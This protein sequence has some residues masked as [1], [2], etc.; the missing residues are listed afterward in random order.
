LENPPTSKLSAPVTVVVAMDDPATAGSVDGYLDW[1]LVA[2]QVQLQKLFDGDHYF[3]R[4]NPGCAAQLV[5]Q[6]AATLR[7]SPPLPLTH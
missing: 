5:K 4:T 7:H 1:Q 2:D 3:L 6:A